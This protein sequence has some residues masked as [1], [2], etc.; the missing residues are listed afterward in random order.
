MEQALWNDVDPP[1][2]DTLNPVPPEVGYMET[3]AWVAAYYPFPN[4]RPLATHWEAAFTCMY[5]TLAW[6]RRDV[7]EQWDHFCGSRPSPPFEAA[8][9]WYVVWGE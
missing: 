2:S 4:P 7:E 5:P 8:G 3:A 6:A 1:A 9:R